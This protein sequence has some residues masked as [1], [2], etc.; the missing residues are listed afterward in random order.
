[1]WRAIQYGDLGFA[2]KGENM[3]EKITGVLVD[4]PTVI[5]QQ[6]EFYRRFD[7]SYANKIIKLISLYGDCLT[8]R[9]RI[10]LVAKHVFCHTQEKISQ[11]L[12]IPNVGKYT[13][14]AESK[15]FDAEKKD[16]IRTAKLD[17]QEQ[18]KLLKD[19]H[20]QEI[21]KLREEFKKYG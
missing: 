12:Y 18:I 11:Y 6:K 4:I 5:I 10:L 2:S 15:L 16:S 7:S 3:S 9:E 17:I 14:R 13:D 20:A 1:M 21:E 8:N 19:K